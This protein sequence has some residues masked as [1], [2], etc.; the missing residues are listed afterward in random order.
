M[1]FKSGDI[2][3]QIWL[4]ESKGGIGTF[5]RCLTWDWSEPRLGMGIEHYGSPL[6]GSDPGFQRWGSEVPGLLLMLV[7]L[8][9]SGADSQTRGSV[10]RWLLLSNGHR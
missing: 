5:Q 7:F 4:E 6:Y 3:I 8:W 2:R 1:G 10:W 9:G